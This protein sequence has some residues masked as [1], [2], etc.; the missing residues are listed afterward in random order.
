[1]EMVDFKTCLEDTELTKLKTTGAYYTW[2]NRT[3]WSKIDRVV[4]NSY[5]YGIMNFIHVKCEVEGL[6]DHTPL[7]VSFLPSP[8]RN[9]PF[10]F[11][12]MWCYDPQFKGIVQ[13]QCQKQRG[14]PQMHQLSSLLR[15][16]QRPLIKMNRD[17]FYDLHSQQDVARR[18]LEAAQEEVQKH[19]T[20]KAL[21]QVEQECRTK[22]TDILSSSLLLIK[23]QSKAFWLNQGDQCSKA[24]MA[25]MRQ[26][27]M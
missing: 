12:E 5:W 17:K 21:L 26:K 6:S 11:C 10:M 20:D 24:F 19:P 13:Y 27:R 23:Q 7:K 16:L 2:T 22:Y 3:I 14:G 8:K 18:K 1:M 9:S 25:K 4:A 15:Q